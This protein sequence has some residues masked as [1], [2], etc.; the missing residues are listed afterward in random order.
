MINEDDFDEI[1]EEPLLTD[2]GFLNEACMNALHKAINSMP[3]SYER[4]AD[5]P[6]WN[7][8]AWTFK[9]DI[10]AELAKWAIGQGPTECPVGLERVV[11]YLDTCLD[12]K[13]S[14]GTEGMCE[15]SL[16][17]I[18]KALYEILYK[19]GIGDFDKWNEGKD[20]IDLHAL[21][22]NICV[23]IRNE[24]REL[25]QPRPKEPSGS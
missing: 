1:I 10:T 23:G 3:K 8:P 20:F 16:C 6:E 18:N 21:L 24:R 22:H 19:Q 4:L 7:T 9:H 25:S 12:H 17:D 14:F 15:L 13:F 11:G 5:T 2:E